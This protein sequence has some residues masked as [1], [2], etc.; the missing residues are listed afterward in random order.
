MS[1]ANLILLLVFIPVKF[2]FYL[3]VIVKCK[4][5]RKKE[6]VRPRC[7]TL[8]SDHSYNYIVPTKTTL[9]Q[10]GGS[11]NLLLTLG[12]REI[13]LVS[14]QAKLISYKKLKVGKGAHKPKA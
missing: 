13:L 12:N 10:P 8:V 7:V 1:I 2:K 6:H 5:L 14:F 4:E 9:A 11:G 3:M